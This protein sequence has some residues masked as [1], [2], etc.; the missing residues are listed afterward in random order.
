MQFSEGHV[1]SSGTRIHYVEAGR[2][3]RLSRGRLRVGIDG[4]TGA[5]KTCFGHELGA[6]IRRRGR[7]S[8]R[9]CFS[10]PPSLN[11]RFRRR[12]IDT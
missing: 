10:S 4:C 6:A 7:P 11:D 12:C 2:I 9:L 8:P 5:G 3:L 1:D